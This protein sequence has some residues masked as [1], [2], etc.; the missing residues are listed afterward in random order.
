MTISLYLG[1]V[2]NRRTLI[3]ATPHGL[4]HGIGMN[5]GLSELEDR[6][7]VVSLRFTG[8]SVKCN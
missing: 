4:S 6:E 5:F 3:L 2:S 7:E 8:F 1:V